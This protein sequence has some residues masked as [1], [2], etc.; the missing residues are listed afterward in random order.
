M[1]IENKKAIYGIWLRKMIVT[2][3]FT[4]SIIG[5][6][7]FSSIPDDAEFGR[8]HIVITISVAFIIFSAIGILRKPYYFYFN[9]NKDVL[10]F[11]FYP[12][13]L[14][15]SKK[16]TVQIPKQQLVK[17]ETSKFFFGLEE[18]LFL[19]QNYRNKVA[20]YPYISLSAISKEERER[21]KHALEKYS[22]QK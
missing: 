10:I 15:N 9:D 19:Y 2:I 13:G 16:N 20:K 11:R 8:Y 7:F 21:L 3:I 18:K 22:Q 4:L 5:V 12:V 6:L 1:I 14:F 17:F